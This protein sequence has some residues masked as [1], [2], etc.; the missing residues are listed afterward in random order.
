MTR[1]LSCFGNRIFRTEDFEYLFSLVSP[2]KWMLVCGKSF[3]SLPESVKSC[4]ERHKDRCVKFDR[5]EPNPKYESVVEGVRLLSENNC[6]LIVAIGGGSAIDVAKCIKLFCGLEENTVYFRQTPD[7]ERISQINLIALPTTAGT[8]SEST[9]HAVIYYNG[10]KQS[11]CDEAII[12]DAVILEPAVL[13]NLPVLHKKAAMLDALCQACES[14]WSKG[15]NEQSILYA[16]KAISAVIDNRKRYLD[17]DADAAAAM[18]KAAND[19]G[20]AIDITKTT[21]AHAMSYKLSALYGLPHGIAVS[22]CFPVVWKHMMKRADEP[23]RNIFHRIAGCFH[24]S[25]AKQAIAYF[26]NML[27]EMEICPPHS[28]DRPRD[29]ELLADSVNPERL[30]N[31][32]IPFDKEKLKEMYGEIVK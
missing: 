2:S 4:Y 5:F 32:P 29:I 22:L 23:L 12:P 19:A 15:A 8:G 3:E 6:S 13:K 14:W 18:L 7:Y 26:E 25:D 11:I 9:R 20:R 24:L 17:G 16:E 27:S 1:A 31:N 10:V 21:A 28:E 30:A